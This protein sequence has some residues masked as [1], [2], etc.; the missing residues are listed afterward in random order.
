MGLEAAARHLVAQVAGALLAL[1]EEE[2][3]PE[4]SR[5][6]QAVGPQGPP[7]RP[8]GPRLLC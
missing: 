3:E 2:V 8:V 5:G 6:P 4:G 1:V 7:G